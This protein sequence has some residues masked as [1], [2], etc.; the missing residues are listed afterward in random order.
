M[1]D[2]PRGELVPLGGVTTVD[3]DA[4][5]GVLVRVRVRVRVARSQ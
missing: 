4:Q 3:G 5:L 2:H 1:V